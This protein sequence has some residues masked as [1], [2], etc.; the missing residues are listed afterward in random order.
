MATIR[1]AMEK[2]DVA[3]QMAELGKVD[4]G[5]GGTIAYILAEY[6]MEVM[7]CGVAVLN[8]HAPYEITSKIDVYETL[9][10]YLAFLK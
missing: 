3:Y 5:G 6:G 7:D 10:G 8:M 9:R 1:S 2:D 4:V